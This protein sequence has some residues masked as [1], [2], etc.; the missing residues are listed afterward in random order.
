[1]RVYSARSRS[2]LGT[3]T[4][5]FTNGLIQINGSAASDRR[6]AHLRTSQRDAAITAAAATTM[7]ALTRR[8]CTCV[9]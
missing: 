2:Y 3:T 6:L 4:S 5:A 9:T 8:S 1:M 7:A